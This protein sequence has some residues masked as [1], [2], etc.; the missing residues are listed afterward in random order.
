MSSSHLA[1]GCS[2]CL[3]PSKRSSIGHYMKAHNIAIITVR[4]GYD[5]PV[6]MAHDGYFTCPLCK[7]IKRKNVAELRVRLAFALL[8]TV[9]YMVYVFQR[10]IREQNCR[11]DS[12]TLRTC[13]IC[14]HASHN[15][16]F[17]TLLIHHPTFKVKYKGGH[18]S[19]LVRMPDGMF[20]CE[21]CNFGTTFVGTIRV[22]G[23]QFLCSCLH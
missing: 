1:R 5:F 8:V 12:Q 19:T 22:S 11:G 6:F 9:T 4:P 10:H 16:W 14:S 18:R 13:K 17:H 3:G 15:L 23:F 7:S 20:R 2:I 21:I